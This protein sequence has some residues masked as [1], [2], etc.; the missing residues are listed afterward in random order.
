MYSSKHK[1][2][3]TSRVWRDVVSVTLMLVVSKNELLRCLEIEQPRPNSSVARSLGGVRLRG[4]RRLVQVCTLALY[5]C[6][7]GNCP[8]LN[9][10]CFFGKKIFYK[11]IA[12]DHFLVMLVAFA[13]SYVV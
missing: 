7:R 9:I 4:G 11:I 5:V 2:N 8:T 1:A 12:I 13:F 3:R 6:L 10:G